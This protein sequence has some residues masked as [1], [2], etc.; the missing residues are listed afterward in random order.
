M[1]KQGEDRAGREDAGG[2]H[3]ADEESV[4]ESGEV[5]QRLD[6]THA[7]ITSPESL[8]PTNH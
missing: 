8:G 2:E 1:A 3:Q 4:T 7:D 5:N 6:R